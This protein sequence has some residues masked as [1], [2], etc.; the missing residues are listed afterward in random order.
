MTQLTITSEPR[1]GPLEVSVYPPD[2]DPIEFTLSSG[3]TAKSLPAQPGRYTVVARRP[4]GSRLR[5]TTVVEGKDASVSLSN[6]VGTTPNE[7][8]QSEAERGEIAP[9]PTAPV[10]SDLGAP[11]SDAPFR[12]ALGAP[13]SGA[14]ADIL[15]RA[16]LD[17]TSLPTLR[18]ER[19]DAGTRPAPKPFALRGWRFDGARWLALESAAFAQTG[20]TWLSDDF[21]KL[22]VRP[23]AAGVGE[24][25]EI[26]CFGLMDG[27]GFG[28]LVILA[29]FVESV[30]LTFVAKGVMTQAAD[31]KTTPGQQR[32]PV[33]LFT[34]GAHAV[35]D[36][37]SALA[38]PGTPPAQTIWN[39]AA[40][41]LAPDSEVDVAGALDVLVHKF[42]RP[43]EALVAAHYVLR[44][45]PNGLPLNWAENLVRVMP[46]AADGPVIAAWTWIYNRPRDATDS[47]VDE[48]VARNVSLALARPVTLFART[49]ALLFDAQH[50]V[51]TDPLLASLVRTQEAFRRAGAAAGGLESFWGKRPDS[52]G[53]SGDAQ[54]GPDL[55]R[56]LLDGETFVPA[57]VSGSVAP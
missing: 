42:R 7:F 39:Q 12:S 6:A 49:R 16:M 33:A 55:Y 1:M 31:R 43:V 28:P 8:M 54:P 34:P 35:A 32:V 44:F 38:A 47:Q 52:P 48:A 13:L 4:N 51:P 25:S 29:P 41:G 26:R 11:L 30:E 17:G 3:M 40:P 15:G 45:L 5:Q 24:S 56:I 46:F 37:L 9:A 14:S 57:R 22:A 19:P 36:F 10:R 23:R 2:G 50:L 53:S 18:G 27:S 20:Q 21:L